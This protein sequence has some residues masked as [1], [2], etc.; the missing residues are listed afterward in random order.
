MAYKIL[1]EILWRRIGKEVV[2][3]R[4]NSEYF[5]L[6]GSGADAWEWLAE[7]V[8]EKAVVRRLTQRYHVALKQAQKDLAALI[9]RLVKA[10][11]L[12]SS[13]PARKSLKGLSKVPTTKLPYSKF[14]FRK[15][16]LQSSSFAWATY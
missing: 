4:P 16:G 14:Q 9:S 15:Y 8:D 13:E 6:T 7:G 10:G 2:I 3:L 1:P 12:L 5:T 11:L